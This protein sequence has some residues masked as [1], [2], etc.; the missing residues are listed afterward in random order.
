ME[1]LKYFLDKFDRSEL[2]KEYPDFIQYVKSGYNS[3]DLMELSCLTKPKS[4][5]NEKEGYY[6]KMFEFK[7]VLGYKLVRIIFEYG[8]Y[9]SNRDL[10]C[11]ILE[12]FK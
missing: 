5:A 8:I 1:T 3:F 7:D 9:K 12:L 10:N 4:F 11:T 6:K 2:R